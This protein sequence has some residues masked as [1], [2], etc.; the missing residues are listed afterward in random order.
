MPYG[1]DFG[2]TNC[3]VVYMAADGTHSRLDIGRERPF[4]SVVAVHRATG[5]T[6]V[7]DEARKLRNELQANDYLVVTSVKK[8][9]GRHIA[10]WGG[11]QQLSPVQIAAKLFEGLRDHAQRAV[12]AGR[13]GEP[14]TSTVVTVPVGFGPARRAALREAAALAGITISDFISEPTAAFIRCRRDLAHVTRAAVFDWGGGT[15]DVSVIQVGGDTIE[16]LGTSGLE[17]AGDDI[18]LRIAHWA[19]AQFFRGRPG[20]PGFDEVAPS[21]RD[22]LLSACESAKIALS[23]EAS[24]SINVARYHGIAA[25]ATLTRSVLSDLVAAYVD[26]SIEALHSALRAAEV[27]PA[28]LDG[29]LLIGGSSRLVAVR[30]RLEDLFPGKIHTPDLP[31]WA[32]GQGAAALAQRPGAYT[33]MQRL[34]LVLSDG[35]PLHMLERGDPIRTR[36]VHHL[37]MVEDAQSAQLIFAETIDGQEE[38]TDLRLRRIGSLAVPMQGFHRERL[39]LETELTGDLT[40]RVRAQSSTSKEGDDGQ[41]Q[42]WEYAQLRFAYSLPPA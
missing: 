1:I 29:V 18:D 8:H 2:T 22:R 4:P 32:V 35:S 11:G 9:L 41:W 25:S 16:E 15:L 6:R 33:L 3:A 17:Q 10:S 13:V 7:G 26:R 36:R 5:E 37:G 34:C 27:R 28:D 14:L 19:H 21:D 24:T 40:L 20:A 38:S 12:A 30:E 23:R 31:D 42:S 39:R